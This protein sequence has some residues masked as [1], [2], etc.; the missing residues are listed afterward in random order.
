MADNPTGIEISNPTLG[1]MKVFGIQPSTLFMI[2]TFIMSTAAAVLLLLHVEETKAGGKEAAQ[3]LK[4]SNKEISD[5]L[6]E[7]NKETQR[8]LRT[9]A[10]SQREANCLNA[11][12]ENQ[13]AQQA[14]F[15]KRISQ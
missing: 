2:F 13:R 9:I 5:A 14:A 11:L 15:C 1:S 6:K 8:I 10:Q 4:E 7:S 3:I 12:P